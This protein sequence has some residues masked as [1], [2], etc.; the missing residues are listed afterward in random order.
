MGKADE[1]VTEFLSKEENFAEVFNH[2]MFYGNEVIDP[3]KLS[4]LDTASRHQ[5]MRSKKRDIAKKYNGQIVCMILGI[6]NQQ[7]IHY[8][9]PLRRKEKK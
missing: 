3:Q 7:H 2:G 8:A 4:D 9:M 5:S 6:E 1:K